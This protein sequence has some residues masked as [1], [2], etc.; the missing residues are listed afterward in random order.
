[1]K[2]KSCAY[3]SL[4]TEAF[5]TPMCRSQIYYLFR[6]YWIPGSY[7][8]AL[9]EKRNSFLR[10]LKNKGFKKESMTKVGLYAI[11]KSTTLESNKSLQPYGIHSWWQCVSLLS[12][13]LESARPLLTSPKGDMNPDNS[14]SDTLPRQGRRPGGNQP[15]NERSV[16]D[17]RGAVIIIDL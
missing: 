12:R 2:E 8:P 11:S 7:A 4:H 5:T 17:P 1:M 16:S 13:W 10:P 6:S 3:G 9:S 14:E 15:A